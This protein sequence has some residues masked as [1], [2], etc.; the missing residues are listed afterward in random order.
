MSAIRSRLGSV[1]LFGTLL[2]AGGCAEG[3]AAP[4]GL[5][6]EKIPAPRGASLSVEAADAPAAAVIGPMGGEIVTPAGNRLVFPAGAVARPTEIR[7]QDDGTH[8]GVRVQPHGLQFP[9]GRGPVLTVRIAPE[10]AAAYAFLRVVYVD[11]AG[12]ILEVLP[13]RTAPGEVSTQLRHF[14]GYL[15]AGG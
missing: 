5:G 6:L 13:T 1:V 7:V 14:S 2:V 10:T 9:A 12:G 15:I 3:P 8:L 11:D 4:A